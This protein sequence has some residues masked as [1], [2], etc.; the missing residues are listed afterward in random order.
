LR[1]SLKLSR[2]SNRPKGSRKFAQIHPDQKTDQIIWA[3]L[4][5]VSE[6]EER[7]VRLLAEE[8]ELSRVLERPDVVLLVELQ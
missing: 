6:G 4:V 2:E 1:F 3:L 8:L 5:V 7:G